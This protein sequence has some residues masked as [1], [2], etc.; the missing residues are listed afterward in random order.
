M[1][2]H[3]RA[4]WEKNKFRCYVTVVSAVQHL[5]LPRLRGRLLRCLCPLLTARQVQAY[6]ILM[7]Y[8]DPARQREYMRLWMKRRRD[9]WVAENGP[10]ID[11][12]SFENLQV[13]HIDAEFKVTHRVWSWSKK[14]REA[15]LA[16]CVVRCR[17]CHAKKTTALGEHARGEKNGSAKLTAAKVLEIRASNLSQRKLAAIYNVSQPTIKD[18]KLRRIWKHVSP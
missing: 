6:R 10:C 8:A 14:R 17:P 13:D 7:P 5:T 15:E 18:I 9:E 16:K 12:G 4:E 2:V 3:R 11:C 1:R